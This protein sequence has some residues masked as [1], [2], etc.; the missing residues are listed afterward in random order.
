MTVG[1]GALSPYLICFIFATFATQARAGGGGA[2]EV[3]G[4]PR[5]GQG[6]QDRLLRLASPRAGAQ[7]RRLHLHA[8]KPTH[9]GR[10][11]EDR[12]QITYLYRCFLISVNMRLFH[13]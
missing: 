13:F 9:H 7:R 8:H 6:R 2:L 5:G 1:T 12:D 4:Y 3:P 11:E 10:P